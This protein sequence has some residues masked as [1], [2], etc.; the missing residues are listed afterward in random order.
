[1]INYLFQEVY[2]CGGRGLYSTHPTPTTPLSAMSFAQLTPTSTVN[3][4]NF[5]N[6]FSCFL[7]P[8]VGP[9]NNILNLTASQCWF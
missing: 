4:N 2:V 1:M 3:T 7:L 6:N 5:N 8:Y 9:W